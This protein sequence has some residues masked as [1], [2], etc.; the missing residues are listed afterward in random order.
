MG[1][2]LDIKI[3]RANKVYHAGVSGVGG[4]AACVVSRI[5]RTSGCPWAGRGRA[6]RCIPC[7]RLVAPP[8]APTPGRVADGGRAGPRGR[9]RGCGAPPRARAAVSQ[10]AQRPHCSG[11]CRELT[12]KGRIHLRNRN[13]HFRL[14][15]ALTLYKVTHFSGFMLRIAHRKNGL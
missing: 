10:G 2:S 11:G 9:R 15:S 1:T 14:W 4:P 5:P 12:E 7:A 8:K 13:V 3:K 6:V